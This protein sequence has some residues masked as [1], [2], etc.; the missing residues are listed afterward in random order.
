MLRSDFK[1]LFLLCFNPL[2]GTNY[3]SD[4]SAPGATSIIIQPPAP[5]PMPLCIFLDRGINMSSGKG[6]PMYEDLP[7]NFNDKISIRLLE[8]LPGAPKDTIQCQLRVATLDDADNTPRYEALSYCWGEEKNEKNEKNKKKIY[9]DGQQ[10]EVMSNLAAALQGLR[11][12]DHIRIL[13]ADAICINQAN[14]PERSFQVSIMSLIYRHADRVVVWL[15]EDEGTTE[16]AL[17]LLGKL[18]EASEKFRD[19]IP[20]PPAW[21]WPDLKE[22]LGI[23]IS[24]L[25][26]YKP[27]PILALNRFMQRPWFGRLWIVQEVTSAKAIDI[28]CGKHHID[29]QKLYNGLRFGAKCRL[30]SDTPDRNANVCWSPF[31]LRLEEKGEVGLLY[32][33]QE[34]RYAGC[35]DPRDKIF[36]H[37]GLSRLTHLKSLLS[38]REEYSSIGIAP[39]YGLSDAEV[40]KRFAFGVIKAQGNLDILSLL[41]LSPRQT[42]SL[43][44][45]VPD[46]Q[47]SIGIRPLLEYTGTGRGTNRYRASGVSRASP[48]L[49]HN[50]LILQGFVYDTL[51]L[52]SNEYEWLM[53]IPPPNPNESIANQVN[54]S[55]I[56][57][58][59][60]PYLT[61]GASYAT[62]WAQYDYI[63][64]SHS[65]RPVRDQTDAYWQTLICA[66][67]SELN[68]PPKIFEQGMDEQLYAALFNTWVCGRIFTRLA[69]RLGLTSHFL[70]VFPICI[71]LD[72]ALLFLLNL[73]SPLHT[74]RLNR[75]MRF[76]GRRLARTRKG[77]LALVTPDAQEGDAI[78]IIQG[79]K[80]PL[81]MRANTVGTWRVLGD[82]YVHG[83]MQGEVWEE[84]KCEEI[85]F[86]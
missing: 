38:L 10:V 51:H 37:F 22:F 11:L 78:G 60:R 1:E 75:F 41:G 34:Y 83:I 40:Y 12:S 5:I 69:F 68:I 58:I 13:W 55:T 21:Y 45:W 44:S 86:V 17:W 46:W 50:T 36:A 4:F 80:T 7:Q 2:L 14:I 63:V 48:R 57:A 39:D 62:L 64:Y 16:Q 27:G 23:K 76:A 6:S 71:L 29:W 20:I 28:R 26:F 79:G 19:V 85:R 81:I 56:W 74:L 67:K 8:L 35:V 15:G 25:E 52:I 77:K 30:A 42:A 61:W 84:L 49:I 33:L 43:P 65:Q 31:I 82:G 59:A 66:S 9:C 54:L 73:R 32:L 24:A 72:M 3:V 18:S 53:E 70:P 47:S